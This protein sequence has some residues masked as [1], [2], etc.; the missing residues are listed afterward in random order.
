MVGV[1][2]GSHRVSRRVA[3]PSRRLP[4]GCRVRLLRAPSPSP[5]GGGTECR[6]KVSCLPLLRPWFCPLQAVLGSVLPCPFGLSM[7][8][9]LPRRSVVDHVYESSSTRLG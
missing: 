5:W 4:I 2:R 3:S 6:L 7:V 8:C 1:V 9:E